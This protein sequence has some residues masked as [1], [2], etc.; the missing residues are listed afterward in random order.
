MLDVKTATN[1]MLKIMGNGEGIWRAI[2]D[3]SAATVTFLRTYIISGAQKAVS[4][5]HIIR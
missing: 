2:G 3:D 4:N 5:G 1:S